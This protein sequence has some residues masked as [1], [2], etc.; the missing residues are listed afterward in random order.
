MMENNRVLVND[1]SNIEIRRELG[2]S[3]KTRLRKFVRT[4]FGRKVVLVGAIAIAMIADDY[5]P[6]GS[7]C[8]VSDVT[9]AATTAN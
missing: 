8:D 1:R 3:R 5:Q 2:N 4:L 7:A 6:C 9:S